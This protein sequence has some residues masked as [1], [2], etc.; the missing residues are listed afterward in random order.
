MSLQRNGPHEHSPVVGQP[1][2]AQQAPPP[3]FSEG[4]H[5]ESLPLPLSTT[6]HVQVSMV[7]MSHDTFDATAPE[8]EEQEIISTAPSD[9]TTDTRMNLRP[10]GAFVMFGRV[11]MGFR[12][13]RRKTT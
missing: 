8:A 1:W 11:Y 10:R 13:C 3:A 2:L 12:V 6:P 9:A 4:E 7:V 5:L